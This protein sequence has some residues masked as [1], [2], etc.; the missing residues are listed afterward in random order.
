VV[1]ERQVTGGNGKNP[2][3]EKSRYGYGRFW[4]L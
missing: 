4:A 3:T 2:Q 1:G